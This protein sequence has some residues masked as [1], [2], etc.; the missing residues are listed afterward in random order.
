[1]ITSKSFENRLL[2]LAELDV[3][4]RDIIPGREPSFNVYLNTRKIEVPS[5]FKQLAIQGEHNAETIWFALD[6]YFDGE[7]LRE[8]AWGIQFINAKKEEMLVSVDYKQLDEDP[9]G[10]TLLL[11]W[12]VPW[13]ITKEAGTVL[14][15][16]FF[17][18]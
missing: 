2:A 7:D 8:K 3:A 17:Q 11:G 12:D 18:S 4:E 15:Y 5:S 10:K 13:D 14:L 6:R 1:M 16:V 9:N